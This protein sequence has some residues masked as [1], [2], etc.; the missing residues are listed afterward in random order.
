MV[1]PGEPFVFPSVSQTVTLEKALG[2]DYLL[3]L[4]SQQPIGD[5]AA[6]TRKLQQTPGTPQQKAAAILPSQG[7]STAEYGSDAMTFSLSTA[8]PSVQVPVLVRL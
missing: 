7:V 1:R 2:E 4:F 8:K 3:F 6:L 5:V